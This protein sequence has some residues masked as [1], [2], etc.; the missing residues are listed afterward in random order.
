MTLPA[1]LRVG[2]TTLSSGDV[3]PAPPANSGIGRSLTSIWTGVRG[4]YRIG[5]WPEPLPTSRLPGGAAGARRS[6]FG[7]NLA[8]AGHGRS[9]VGAQSPEP[10]ILRGIGLRDFEAEP[11]PETVKAGAA[12]TGAAKTG[13]SPLKMRKIEN[14]ASFKKRTPEFREICVRTGLSRKNLVLK[15]SEPSLISDKFSPC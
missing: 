3:A 9:Q 15:T 1:S 6:S 12:G 7:H 2:S 11:S 4:C 13:I 10:G 5:K 14:K 8:R